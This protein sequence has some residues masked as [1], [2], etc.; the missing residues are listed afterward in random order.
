MVLMQSGN[1]ITNVADGTNPK[2]AVN[3]SQLDT[4]AN[5]AKA[6]VTEGNNIKVDKTTNA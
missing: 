6:I 1:K 4:A 5:A 3:K 2:D